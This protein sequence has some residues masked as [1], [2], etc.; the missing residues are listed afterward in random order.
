MTDEP[1]IIWAWIWN[2]PGIKS[3]KQSAWSTYEPIFKDWLTRGL[4]TKKNWL[5]LKEVHK[6]TTAKYIRY[7]HHKAYMTDTFA[8]F[9]EACDQITELKALNETT[10]KQGFDDGCAHIK[11][12]YDAFAEV[13]PRIAELETALANVCQ[14]V[15]WQEYGECRGWSDEL[16]SFP[17]ALSQ[18]RTVLKLK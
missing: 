11:E 17:D 4:P 14:A 10:Y 8:A 16:K 9:E 5:G 15:V 12:D 2:T 18:A 1:K 13:D 7:E 3:H 6:Q